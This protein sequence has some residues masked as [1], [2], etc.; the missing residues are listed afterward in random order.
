MNRVARTPVSWK[1]GGAAGFPSHSCPAAWAWSPGDIAGRSCDT[2]PCTRPAFRPGSGRPGATQRRSRFWVACAWSC[3][4]V[5]AWSRPCLR[6]LASKMRPSFVFIMAW[7]YARSTCKQG[8]SHGCTVFG[9]LGAGISE[10]GTTPR[11]ACRVALRFDASV[12]HSASLETSQT[13]RQAARLPRPDTLDAATPHPDC[14]HHDLVCRGNGRRPLRAVPSLLRPDSCPQ[15]TATWQDLQRL[16]R[17]DAP[18]A[19]ARLVG[20]L[21]C[22]TVASSTSWPTA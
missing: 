15:A 19:H 16:L 9:S 20:L 18:S 5:R 8:R 3:C 7:F 13:R 2:A 21:R 17:G 1:A 6:E 4:L 14:R 22:R 11:Q 10:T 12:C